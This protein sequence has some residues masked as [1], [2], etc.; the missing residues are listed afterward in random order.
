MKQSDSNR[1]GLEIKLDLEML[2]RISASS[3]NPGMIINWVVLRYTAGRANF[4]ARK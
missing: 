3:R 4:F 2:A 1:A